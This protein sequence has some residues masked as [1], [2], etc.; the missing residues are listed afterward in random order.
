MTGSFTMSG[1]KINLSRRLAIRRSLSCASS[2][3]DRRHDRDLVLLGHFGLE[4]G[5]EAHILVVQIDVHELSKLP[6]GVEEALLESRITPVQ[7]VDRRSQ[8]GGFYGHGHLAIG[9]A[10]QRTRDAKLLAVLVVT[11]SRHDFIVVS[12]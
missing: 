12:L 3:G 8:I 10:T 6:T 11:F 1:P 2:P 4:A 7:R 9:E 5:A